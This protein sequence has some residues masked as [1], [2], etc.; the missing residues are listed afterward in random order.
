MRLTLLLLLTL[1]ASPALANEEGD[2]PRWVRQLQAT[3]LHRFDVLVKSTGG[4]PEDEQFYVVKVR[5]VSRK[6]QR[7]LQQLAVNSGV[8]FGGP[9]EG[10]L[11]VADVNFDGRPDFYVPSFVGGANSNDDFFLFQPARGAFVKHEALSALFG[12]TVKR[13][14]TISAASTGGCCQHESATYRFVG[15]RLQKI[16]SV[17]EVYTQ[18]DT[19]R[20]TSCKRVRSSMRCTTTEKAL[21][22]TPG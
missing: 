5:V 2:A 3:A 20:T 18:E 7:V 12:V 19:R 11:K 21:P 10:L 1:C 22:R 17:E 6:G 9:P 8:P 14:R 15:N 4:H 16:A 13:N